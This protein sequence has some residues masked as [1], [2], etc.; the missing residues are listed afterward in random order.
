MVLT[1][2]ANHIFPSIEY[3]FR[4]M[5]ARYIR[6]KIDITQTEL[7]TGSYSEVSFSD[8]EM[9]YHP[10]M[11]YLRNQGIEKDNLIV[12][13]KEDCFEEV[14]SLDIEA[15]ILNML[16]QKE[17]VLVLFTSSE[18][19][20]FEIK[21]RLSQ[22]FDELG[23]M[24]VLL[25]QKEINK[26]KDWAEQFSIDD[27]MARFCD[28][29]KKVMVK[30][31]LKK[32]F[33]LYTLDIQDRFKREQMLAGQRSKTVQMKRKF[34]EAYDKALGNVTIACKIAGVK[35]RKTF[36]NWVETDPEFRKAIDLPAKMRVDAAEDKLMIQIHKG[37]GPS[38]R[39]FLSK[40]HPEY[41]TR[42]ISL[43]PKR[44][45]DPW[46]KWEKLSWDDE[47]DEKDEE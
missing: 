23:I 25:Q 14:D 10:V 5:N 16:D 13:V 11:R 40:I 26:L 32:P 39:H 22:V 3:I 42:R 12:R 8:P 46:K 21:V 45:Y 6:S 18:Y 41:R 15:N 28:L 30:R 7:A 35:S 34:L 43:P 4:K 47:D 2:T 19:I 24:I 20:P 38:I 9:K 44:E 1:E 36:Y 37:D 17:T 33:D 31:V 29:C 27:C